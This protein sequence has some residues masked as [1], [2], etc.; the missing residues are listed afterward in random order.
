MIFIYIPKLCNNPLNVATKRARINRTHNFKGFKSPKKGAG[1]GIFQPNWQNH[2]V[3]ISPTAKIGSTPNFY[4]VIEPY[5]WLCR[6]SRMTKFKLKMADSRHIAKCWKCYKSRL[7][8][9][10]FGRYLGRGILSC[11]PMSAMMR[12]CHGNYHCLATAHWIFSSYGRLEAERMNQFLWNLVHNGKLK[13]PWQSRDQILTFVKLKMA[14]G[15]HVWNI[16]IAITR[17]P[18]DRFG[19]HLRGRIASHHVP[20]MCGCHGIDCCLATGHWTFSS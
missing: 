10:W 19:W 7:S 5:S 20:D 4:T 9:D 18:M 14:D 11:P 1:L 3:A 17:L 6:W 8:M 15:N 16:G 13:I 12:C 2:K